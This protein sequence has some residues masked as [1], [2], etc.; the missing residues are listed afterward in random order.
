MIEPVSVRLAARLDVSGGPDSCWEYQAARSPRG[1][2]TIGVMGKTRRAHRVAWELA[3]G[4]IPEGLLVCHHCDNPPCCNPAHLFLGTD[5]D[6]VADMRAKG[7]GRALSG[8]EWRRVNL[9]RKLLTHCYRG[10]EFTA[11]N[12]M[13]DG[14]GKRHCIECRR[15]RGRAQGPRP[16]RIRHAKSK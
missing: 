5:K 9:P 4:P 12:T 14:D 1:Y 13:V 2:G 15:I 8:E 11:L 6:N 3:N 10:H 16:G 7:R